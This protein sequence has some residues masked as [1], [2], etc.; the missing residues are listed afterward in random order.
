[1]LRKS[2]CAE[3]GLLGSYIVKPPLVGVKIANFLELI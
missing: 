1:M 2:L 3:E